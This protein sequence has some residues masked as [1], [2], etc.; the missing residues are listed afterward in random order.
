GIP[1]A[2][3]S[4]PVHVQ[5]FPARYSPQVGWEGANVIFDTWVH[6]LVMGLEEHLLHMFRE[7]FEFHDAAGPSHHGG[8]APAAEAPKEIDASGGGISGQVKQDGLVIWLEPAEKELRKIPFFVRGKARR[9]TE[10]F[11]AEKGVSEISVDTL[12]E[13]KAHYAR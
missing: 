11:A 10:I 1:C 3:I 9:N 7:D 5:D 2:V 13:A 4:A 6:P 12:Y 8:H